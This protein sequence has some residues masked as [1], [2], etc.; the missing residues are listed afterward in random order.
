MKIIPLLSLK[1]TFL[2]LGGLA[3]LTVV[4]FV[5]FRIGPLAP[6]KIT[7][8]QVQNKS[9]NPT[10]FGIGGVEAQQS[11]LLG[12]LVAGRV[13]RIHVKV[14]QYVKAGQLLAEMDPLDL[15]E[16]HASQEA[17]LSRAMSSLTSAQAQLE[18]AQTRRAVANKNWVRQTELARENFISQGA[19]EVHEQE[20]LSSNAVVK[21]GQANVT[22][23][24]QD[25]K[26]IQAEKQ[27]ALVQRQSMRLIAPSNSVVTSR[28][29]EA[30]STVVAGQAVLRLS[31][32]NS[33]WIKMRVDQGRSFGLAVGLPAVIVL[34]S[35]P[36]QNLS[37]K[38]ERV[39]WQSDAVTEEKIVQVSFDRLPS[40]LSMGEM[41]EV[42]LILPATS[43]ALVLP[44]ASVQQFQGRTGVWK[45]MP[46]QLEFVDVKLGAFST[47][48]WV[49]VLGGLKQGD[50]V[51]VYSEKPL[52]SQT[53]FKVVDAL[54]T[55]PH[56]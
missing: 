51:V 25:I 11:W 33:F 2:I 40:N 23:A 43:P 12:P 10:I 54:I 18:D 34:R 26:R 20:L 29:A 24:S 44:Q 13:L 16:R 31:Q 39:E 36:L 7:A 49:Q 30:G 21:V 4:V 1:R 5:A 41:A 17:A 52:S 45:L 50:E 22:S 55:K 53:R 9:L 15:N 46:H 27:A 38:V 14:G 48:G 6:V 19:L 37:G 56:T 47:E 3:L 32:P 28:D 8:F 35:N 42:T